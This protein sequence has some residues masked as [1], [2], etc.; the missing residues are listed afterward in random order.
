MWWALLWWALLRRTDERS[1]TPQMPE[2]PGKHLNYICNMLAESILNQTQIALAFFE[3]LQSIPIYACKFFT[4]CRL[5]LLY[6]PRWWGLSHDP[7]GNRSKKRSDAERTGIL[8]GSGHPPW[9][10]K[11]T[12]HHDCATWAQGLRSL[13]G[14]QIHYC[15]CFPS[16]RFHSFSCWVVHLSMQS[17]MDIAICIILCICGCFSP[18][19]PY[20][21]AHLNLYLRTSTPKAANYGPPP[22][23]LPSFPS[24]H[25]GVLWL[26]PA[27]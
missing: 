21:S 5:H 10:G 12:L 26:T 1:W 24:C 13:E 17:F 25:G 15:K 3:Q 18:I 9:P 8:W 11:G 16:I 6:L 23:G 14:W 4:G 20:L 27:V 2:V 19:F 7:W 22:F